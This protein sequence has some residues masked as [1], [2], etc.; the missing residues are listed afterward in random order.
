MSVPSE[1]LE[2]A[3]K[4]ESA[5]IAE[6]RKEAV[7]QSVAVRP[8]GYA[9][10]FDPYAAKDRATLGVADRVEL[11]DLV[12]Q[13][14]TEGAQLKSQE[15]AVA[16]AEGATLRNITKSQS[17]EIEYIID[18]ASRGIRITAVRHGGGGSHS[19]P[20]DATLAKIEQREQKQPEHAPAA[21][22]AAGES[23]KL[24]YF[25]ICDEK[26]R[27]ASLPL[28]NFCKQQGFEVVL[29]AF[30]GVSRQTLEDYYMSGDADALYNEYAPEV[31]KTNQQNLASCDAVL[32]WYGAGDEVWF[33]LWDLII[34]HELEKLAV[35]RTGK[36][37]PPKYTYLAEPRT[38]D[39]EDLI[40]MEEP[41]PDQRTGRL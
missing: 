4:I 39:K 8:T 7:L 10:T 9:I 30:E 23:T 6:K 25:I 19:S 41:G 37:R 2:Q 32:L 33:Y 29:S 31:R 38:M 27:K 15:G 16:R 34:R 26:D 40:D 13:L 36:P 22:A 12:A 21:K 17:V 3:A 20:N 24:I 5:Q 18:Q 14:S 11:E 28:R 1:L 35:Y